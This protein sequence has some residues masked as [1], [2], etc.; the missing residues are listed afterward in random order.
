EMAWHENGRVRC[1]MVPRVLAHA[2]ADL[3]AVA[4]PDGRQQSD[5][6]S[7]ALQHRVGRHRRAMYEQTASAQQVARRQREGRGSTV[8]RIE[9][10]LRRI[11]GDG[12]DLEYTDRAAG[13][14]EYQ[15]GE[16]AA[17]IHGDAPGI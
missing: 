1:A 10:A 8:E 17:D 14:R 2:A 13:I 16:R 6:G 15:I 9:D 11:G 3:E 12:G 7:L 5:F 4:E